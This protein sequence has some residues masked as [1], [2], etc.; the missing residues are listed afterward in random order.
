MILGSMVSLKLG[1]GV[2]RPKIVV[3]VRSGTRIKISIPIEG[4]KQVRNASI[5]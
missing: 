2:P 3:P 5:A 4:R 1:P